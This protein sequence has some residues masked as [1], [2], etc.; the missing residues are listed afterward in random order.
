[1]F[2]VCLSNFAGKDASVMNF[3]QYLSFWNDSLFIVNKNAS[4]VEV[5]VLR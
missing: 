4:A 2:F 1:M 3:G 5:F